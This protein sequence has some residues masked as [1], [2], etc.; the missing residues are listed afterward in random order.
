MLP[1]LVY[2]AAAEPIRRVSVN[3][4]LIEFQQLFPGVIFYLSMFY[5][6]YEV[7]KSFSALCRLLVIL[8]LRYRCKSGLHISLV[9]PRLPAHSPAY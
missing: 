5:T 2:V 4:G 9:R 6:R 3:K 1:K 8:M 7:R